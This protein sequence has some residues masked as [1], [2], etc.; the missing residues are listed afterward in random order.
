MIAG[1]SLLL[2]IPLGMAGVVYLL[3]RW[4]R[5]AGLLAVLTAVL[6]ALLVS[7]LPIDRPIRLWGAPPV[8]L[9]E[10]ITLF[11]RELTLEPSDRVAMAFLFL[12]AAGIFLLAWRFTAHTLLFPFGLGV[13]SLLCGALLIRPLIYAALLI[14]T[15]A[16]LSAATLQ[17]ERRP[18]TR[19]GLR[20]L[21][22]S[23]L[24]LPGLLATHWLL[25]RYALTP[26]ETELLGTAAAL[27]AISFALLL[28]VFPFHTWVPA[29]ARDGAPLSGAFVLTVMNSGIWF[30]L[31]NFLEEFPWLNEYPYFSSFVF[32]AGLAMV[33]LG[34]IAAATQQRLASVSGYAALADSGSALIAL[35]LGNRL[36]PTLSLLSLFARPFGLLL[37]GAGLSGILRSARTDDQLTALEGVGYRTPWSV[38]ALAMGG[39]SM[40]G[41]PPSVGF[42]WRW[43]LCRALVAADR[44]GAAFVLLLAGLGVMAGVARGVT[45]LLN[46][47]P[48]PKPAGQAS[49]EEHS[50]E[51]WLTVLL[52]AFFIALAIAAGI[53]P[54]G[55][56]GAATRLVETYTFFG[57]P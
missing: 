47:P 39:L 49:S 3:L 55:I 33:V 15:A 8:A 24:A 31:L 42:A 20:Y 56:A 13:L 5:A 10:T 51:G 11:G 7:V 41:I 40:A 14:E 6:L 22:F 53:F 50:G 27:I 21:A 28:G 25:E 37:L 4:R 16:V 34:G 57:A 2:A 30:L 17:M 23:I 35:S 54:Q 1:I 45:A 46:G 18:F 38:A 43:S 29:I 44:S 32:A 19:G 12:S 9:G 26:N 36:G 52:L 48:A